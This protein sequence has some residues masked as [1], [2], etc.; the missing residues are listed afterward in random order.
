MLR[1]LLESQFLRAAG[2]Y[3]KVCL[4]VTTWWLSMCKSYVQPARTSH[5]RTVACDIGLAEKSDEKVRVVLR[6][7]VTWCATIPAFC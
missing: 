1:T 4:V 7:R 5:F 6:S 3:I 2:D